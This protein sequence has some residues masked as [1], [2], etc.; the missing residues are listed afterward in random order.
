M[1]DFGGP[2][3]DDLTDLWF[4]SLRQIPDTD[5]TET[6]E[7]LESV[8]GVIKNNGPER[9]RYLLW[10]ALRHARLAGVDLGV[11]PGEGALQVA[12]GVGAHA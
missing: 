6:V 8:N 5:P 10:Q 1:N 9:A 12:E 11:V 2:P 4:D 3:R 7:W